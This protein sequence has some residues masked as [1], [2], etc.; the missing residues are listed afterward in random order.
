MTWP[1]PQKVRDN[2]S[3]GQRPEAKWG[4]RKDFWTVIC[5]T[6]QAPT[7]Q[8]NY[9]REIIIYCLPT[10]SLSVSIVLNAENSAKLKFTLIV[11]FDS[12]F[13]VPVFKMLLL[14]WNL[15]WNQ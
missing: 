13:K 11:F 7:G 3:T 15:K 1:F 8:A 6:L 10:L 12:F 2:V 14:K 4:Q 9:T 5:D